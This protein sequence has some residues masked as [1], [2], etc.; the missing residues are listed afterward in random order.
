MQTSRRS[1][2]ARL[3]IAAVRAYCKYM[4]P[5]MLPV[6]RFVPS[7]SQYAEEALLRH[8]FLRGLWLTVLRLGRCTPLSQPGV[9][10]V[11]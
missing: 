10:P 9:D 5:H 11:K 8:G 2:L 1:V 7:C 4:S 3:A 6:C